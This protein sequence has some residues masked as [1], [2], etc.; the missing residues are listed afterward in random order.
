[1]IGVQLAQCPDEALDEL[2]EV[3]ALNRDGTDGGE[4]SGLKYT[5][6]SK[7]HS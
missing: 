6:R 3:G 2:V 5:M 4:F 7:H 1:M